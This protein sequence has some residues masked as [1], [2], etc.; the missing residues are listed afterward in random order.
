MRGSRRKVG[1]DSNAWCEPKESTQ[2]GHLKGGR[3]TMVISRQGLRVLC[4]GVCIQSPCMQT[5]RQRLW[6]HNGD[7]PPSFRKIETDDVS[8]ETTVQSGMDPP[9]E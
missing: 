1:T 8:G 7:F 6:T 3:G 2:E 5:G 9:T 4:C